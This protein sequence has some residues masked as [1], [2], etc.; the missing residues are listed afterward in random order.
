MKFPKVL[1]V[2]MIL[3]P[4]GVGAGTGIGYPS[5]FEQ[6]TAFLRARAYHLALDRFF[7]AGEL[8]RDDAERAE[9]LRWTGEAHLRDKQYDSA[10]HDFL[11]SLRLDPLSSNASGTEFKSAV[12]L[13][14]GKKY[15]DSLVHLNHLAQKNTDI[16]TLSDIYFWQAECYYQLGQYQ[17]AL[18]LYQTLLDKN[19]GYKHALLVNYLM[20]W[21]SFQQKDFQT[22]YE[23]FK[24]LAS[25]NTDR[26]LAELSAFQ[27]AE[28]QFW[29]G[30]YAEAQTA[31]E[32]FTKTYA[33]D[34]M[35]AAAYYGWGWSLAKQEQHG[36]ASK[37]FKKIATDFPK[38]SLAPWAAL[39][40]G[41]E[42]FA[43]GDNETA[44][45]DYE[46]GL[47][48]CAGKTPADFLQYGLG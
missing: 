2:T 40:A 5:L 18:K 3:V 17:D 37:I 16:Q 14:Y 13:V 4:G 31:Y 45:K 42:D 7:L 27:T 39:R 15:N 8:S 25:N 9:A 11:T 28:C 1:L 20:D 43:S 35:E 34:D 30:H 23:G 21:C 24:K 36:P 26:N 6:G 47:T 12:A 44:R 22:A 46:M 38:D 32:Q 10:Y 48:L 29:L 19:P 33:G 41:A